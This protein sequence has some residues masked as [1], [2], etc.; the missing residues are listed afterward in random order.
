MSGFVS[1]DLYSEVLA[2]VPDYFVKKW[3][4]DKPPT[5]EGER[6]EWCETHREI[7]HNDGRCHVGAFSRVVAVELGEDEGAECRTVPALIVEVDDE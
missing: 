6:I 1:I 7:A 3:G 2:Y 4:Y 5:Y